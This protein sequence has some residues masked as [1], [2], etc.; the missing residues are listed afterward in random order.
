MILREPVTI[1]VGI[2]IAVMLFVGTIS[3]MVFEP[4]CDP[5]VMATCLDQK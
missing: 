1:I 4:A 5:K 3:F 2:V